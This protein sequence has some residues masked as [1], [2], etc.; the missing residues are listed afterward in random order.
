M[1]EL[2]V[3]SDAIQC[4]CGRRPTVAKSRGGYILTCP[5]SKTCRYVPNGGRYASLHKAVEGWNYVVNF[6]RKKEAEQN[7]NS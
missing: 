4:L 1:S 2:I 5:A 6:L 7:A 3:P